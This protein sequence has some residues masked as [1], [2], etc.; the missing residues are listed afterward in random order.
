MGA[1]LTDREL[2]DRYAR[3]DNSAFSELVRRHQH[4][5]HNLCYRV[6]GPA[7]AED[8]TQEIF[9]RLLDKVCLWRGESKFSTWLYRVALNQ[10]RDLLRR[11]RPETVEIDDRHAD[12][13]PSPQAAVET[14]ETADRIFAAM[15]QLSLDFRTIVFL[16]D[17]EGCGYAEIAEIL[18]L[19]PGTVKSRLARARARLCQ[20]L[21]PIRP[22]EHQSR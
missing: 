9:I 11:R 3:G 16:R 10:C 7:D 20:L 19:E 12:P 17:V 4:L 14:H 22:M 18:E 1:D 5:V 8:L 13:G 15:M 21:E 6:A 2:V